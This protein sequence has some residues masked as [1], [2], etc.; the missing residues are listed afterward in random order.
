MSELPALDVQ[1]ERYFDIYFAHDDAL[2]EAAFGVRYNVYC[3]EFGFEPLDRFPDRMERD[4]LDDVSLHC[5]VVHK[6]SGRPAGCL[7]LIPGEADGRKL[8]LPFENASPGC[9]EH[10]FLRGKSISR[11]KICEVSRLAVDSAF[12]RRNGESIT[13]VGQ[14]ESID[15][16]IADARAFNI[17]SEAV[18]LAGLAMAKIVGN[19][20]AFAMM[21]PF[22]PRILRRSGIDFQQIGDPVDYHGI[23]APF[24]ASPA[25]VE[26][27]IKSNLRPLYQYLYKKLD[28]SFHE[29][30]AVC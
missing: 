21:E 19:T 14:S 12:R 13:R 25:D 24:I 11:A 7:R 30:L 2:K 27:N 8:T 22:L 4:E 26:A 5:V 9:L 3:Q 20:H 1:F 18:F 28:E 6:A 23:R 17:V 15:P 10:E 16:S 29:Q